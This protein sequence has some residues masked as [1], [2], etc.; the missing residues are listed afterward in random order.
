MTFFFFKLNSS[1]SLHEEAREER[2]HQG[3]LG[4]VVKKLLLTG[5]FTGC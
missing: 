2:V 5:L 1:S 3:Y 4:L